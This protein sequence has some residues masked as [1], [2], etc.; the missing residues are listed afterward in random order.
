MAEQ[1]QREEETRREALRELRLP[2]DKPILFSPF[3]ALSIADLSEIFPQPEAAPAERS[4]QEVIDGTNV[5][6]GPR[7]HLFLNKRLRELGLDG[8][9]PHASD[10]DI[11]R[12]QLKADISPTLQGCG[13]AFASTA[14]KR[15]K[16]GITGIREVLYKAA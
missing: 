4:M 12:I 11:I 10:F 16:Y 14:Y 15:H 7:D 1:L 3:Q 9:K 8:D 5:G 6:R 13:H 2:E